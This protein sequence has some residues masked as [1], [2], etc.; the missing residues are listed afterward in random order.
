MS[1]QVGIGSLGGTAFFR[2]GLR[3]PLWTMD[4]ETIKKHRAVLKSITRSGSRSKASSS[5]SASWLLTIVTKGSTLD[6]AR[7]LIPLCYLQLQITCKDTIHIP[8]RILSTYLFLWVTLYFGNI[9]FVAF[10]WAA[11]NKTQKGFLLFYRLWILREYAKLMLKTMIDHY[12]Q[13]FDKL[14]R[15]LL[16]QW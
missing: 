14:P 15:Y 3:N 5:W 7:F 13:P 10:D 4:K 16:S 9:L 2:V 8:H 12:A 6:T 11:C 1:F